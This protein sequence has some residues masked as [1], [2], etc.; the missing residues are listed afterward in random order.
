MRKFVV[1]SFKG[2][3]EFAVESSADPTPAADE[4]L[5]RLTAS[6][7]TFVDR[8]IATGR[9]QVKPP[10]PFTPGAVGAGEVLSL[11]PGVQGVHPGDRV[12]AL[13]PGYGLWS[14]HAT[15]PVNGFA[16]IPDGVS[17]DVAAAA[18]EAYGTARFALEDRGRLRRGE[19]V[20]VHGATGAVGSAAVEIAHLLGAEVVAT[21]R[22]PASWPVGHAQPHDVIDLEGVADV[23][24]VLRE[25]YRTGFDIIIDP[26]GGALAEPSVRSLSFGGRYLVVGF[27][28]G[29][30]PA[31]ATNLALLRN[32]AIL[33]VEWA[34]WIVTYPDQIRA[35]MEV[36]LERLARNQHRIP[37][38]T[39]VTLDELP[40]LLAGS[41]PQTGLLRTLVAPA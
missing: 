18:I 40:A 5:V 34:S 28:S 38:P 2:H 14:T 25:H 26:V 7:V 17:D 1:R 24:G 6:N 13:K 29:E 23:R 19:R 15:V 36:V 27:A 37:P 16:V 22:G 35:G 3:G 8:L 31:V 39:L 20:L 33:G 4:V 32:R 9:Y 11:G 21:T 41:A 12:V 10:T 30:I